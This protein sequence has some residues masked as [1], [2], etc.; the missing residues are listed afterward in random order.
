[1]STPGRLPRPAARSGNPGPG[2]GR[3]STITGPGPRPIIGF[4]SLRALRPP[5]AAGRADRAA[6]AVTGPIR[7][8]RRP[9]RA[10]GHVR[11]AGMVVRP[12]SRPD[13]IAGPSAQAAARPAGGAGSVLEPAC[14]GSDADTMRGRTSNFERKCASPRVAYGRRG[15]SKII[16][17]RGRPFRTGIGSFAAGKRPGSLPKSNFSHQLPGP[18]ITVRTPEESSGRGRGPV[19]GRE[20]RQRTAVARVDKGWLEVERQASPP[21]STR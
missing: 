6:P 5:G 8:A 20:A 2:P 10:H 7:S 18:N 16:L 14:G 9:L 1:M 17:L 13:I 12:I 4:M 19:S 11:A 15:G 21:V 3:A